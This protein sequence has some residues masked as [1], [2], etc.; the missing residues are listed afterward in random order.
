MTLTLRTPISIGGLQ[1]KNRLIMAPMQQYKGTLE[2]FATDHHVEHYGRRAKHVGL[3]IVESTA[4]SSN[5]RLWSN[6]IGIFTDAHVKYLKK[7]TEAVHVHQTP[8]FIQLSHGGRKSA[9]EVTDSLVAPSA[10]AFDEHYGTPEPLSLAGIHQIIEEYRL[11]AKRSV[12]AGFD[13]IEIHAAHGFLIHQ[14]V[15][16]LSNT[17]LDDY[18]GSSENRA[19]FLKEVLTAIRG[20]VGSDYPLI[21]RISAT[22]YYEG[23]LTPEEWARIVKPLESELDAIHVSTGGNLSIPPADVY[24]AYQLPQ[25]AAIKQHVQ[26]PVIAV[27]KIYSQSL[28][29]HILQDQLADCIAIGRPLLDDP[30]FAEHLLQLAAK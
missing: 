22:D 13:G 29:N 9:P 25:A 8:V 21:I 2:A 7:I 18:G 14:F 5:G 24:T 23:G 1:L 11:A 26:I 16:P 27:G 4:I 6:D 19:R 20:E 28:A 17:R 15:S 30:D 12:A 3:V 10:I